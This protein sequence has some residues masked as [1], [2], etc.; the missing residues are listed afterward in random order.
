MGVYVVTLF[1][2]D[3]PRTATFY[4]QPPSFGCVISY[5]W[6]FIFFFFNYLFYMDTTNVFETKAVS[7]VENICHYLF[8]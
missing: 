6:L 3:N 2:Y 5:M 1:N 4:Y 8:G 7:F